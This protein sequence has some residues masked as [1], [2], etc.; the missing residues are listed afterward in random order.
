MKNPPEYHRYRLV[1]WGSYVILTAVGCLC[2]AVS[3]C[4]SSH[5]RMGIAPPVAALTEVDGAARAWCLKELE[6]LNT[7]LNNRLDAMLSSWPARR[8]GVEWEDW[9]P[10]W[11]GRLLAVG[12]RCRLSEGDAPGTRELAVAWERLFELHRHYTTLAVQFSGE[13]G[14]HSDKVHHAMDDARRAVGGQP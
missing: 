9:S 13:I 8:S 12:S 4:T 2:V 6:S 5:A 7:E 10:A 1:V 3:V 14:P 11:R